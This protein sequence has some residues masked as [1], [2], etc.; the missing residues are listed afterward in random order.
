MSLDETVMLFEAFE[1]KWSE[2][3]AVA[4][5]RNN[6]D[7]V[8]RLFEYPSEIRKIIYTTNAIES[9]HNKLRKVTD[10]K[11]AFYN[12]T[13]LYKLVYLRTIDIKKTWSHPVQN[14]GQVMNQLEVLFSNRIA[15]RLKFKLNFTQNS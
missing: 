1:A 9:Y 3:A 11:G 6:W 7:A 14:W 8:E 2:T 5:W 15:P 12:E 4:V 10:L 13:A